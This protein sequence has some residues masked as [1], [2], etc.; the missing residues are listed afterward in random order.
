MS[1]RFAVFGAFVAVTT[2]LLWPFVY[3]YWA[4]T[5]VAWGSHEPYFPWLEP[6]GALLWLM[7]FAYLFVAGLILAV[8]GRSTTAVLF[9]SILGGLFSLAHFLLS[10][11]WFSDNASFSAYLWTYGFYLIPPLGAAAGAYAMRIAKRALVK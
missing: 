10:K 11:N 8:P 1:W 5:I 2:W 9:A 6:A 7:A 3:Q 4:N